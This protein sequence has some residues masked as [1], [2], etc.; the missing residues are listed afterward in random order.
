MASNIDDQY[1]ILHNLLNPYPLLSKQFNS[2]SDLSNLI[3]V[4][5][6]NPPF[7]YPSNHSVIHIIGPS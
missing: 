7:S 6:S 2:K 3:S 1:F 5:F 4:F